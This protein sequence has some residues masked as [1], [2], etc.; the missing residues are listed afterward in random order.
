MVDFIY[1]TS[2]DIIQ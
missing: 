2:F 1:F